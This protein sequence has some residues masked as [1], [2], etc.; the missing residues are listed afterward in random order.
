MHALRRCAPL[1]T[2]EFRA[3]RLVI[4]QAHRFSVKRILRLS[5]VSAREAKP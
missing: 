3:Q 1:S 2:D 4:A 5:A